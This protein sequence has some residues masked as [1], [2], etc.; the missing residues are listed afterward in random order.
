MIWL[1]IWLLI[2]LY[3]FIVGKIGLIISYKKY[4]LGISGYVYRNAT[5]YKLYIAVKGLI[6]QS[7]K[8][9]GQL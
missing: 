5:L 7:L 8:S 3:L 2:I 9:I 6:M 4:L 1:K